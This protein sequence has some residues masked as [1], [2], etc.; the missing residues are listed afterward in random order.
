MINITFNMNSWCSIVP[1]ISLGEKIKA[2][3]EYINNKYDDLSG[4][5]SINIQELICGNKAKYVKELETAFKDH[6]KA[7]TPPSF[8][9]LAHPKSI[10][11]VTLINSSIKY[12]VI[13]FAYTLPNRTIYF[14]VSLDGKLFRILNYYAVQT[15]KL[16]TAANWYV[17]QRLIQKENL[18]SEVIAEATNCSENSIPLLILGDMQ[19]SSQDIHIRQLLKLGFKEKNPDYFPTTR[20][21]SENRIDHMLYSREAWNDPAFYPVSMDFDGNLLDTLSDHVLLAT[22]TR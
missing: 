5:V 9:Y 7:V 4:I 3:A 20:G 12:R 13:P 10:M 17:A 15:Q 6:F 11:N 22:S 1:D 8:R 14:E 2:F 21:F 18:W 19:E 16:S